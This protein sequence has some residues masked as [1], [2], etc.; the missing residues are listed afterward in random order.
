MGFKDKQLRLK[1]WAREKEQILHRHFSTL[2]RGFT[3]I[4]VVIWLGIFAIILTTV[5][6]VIQNNR[7]V[8]WTGV[9]ASAP[10]TIQN[11]GIATFV[12]KVTGVSVNRGKFNGTNRP[13]QFILTIPGPGEGVIQSVTDAT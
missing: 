6:F 12:Y 13:V 2:H 11:G 4:E 5:G 8:E 3:V 9:F 7:S 1:G 10:T